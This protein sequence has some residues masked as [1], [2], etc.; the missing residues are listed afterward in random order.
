MKFAIVVGF[1]QEA[2]IVGSPDNAVVIIGG[3]NA[4]KLAS[5]LNAAIDGGCD[6]VLSFGTW[7]ALDPA[8]KAGEIGVG[9]SL[10][11][12]GLTTSCDRAWALSLIAATGARAV[13]VTI[14]AETVATAASK[15]ALRLR[16]RADVV[17]FE[18]LVAA[19]VA[20]NRG[21]K[22]AALRSASDTADQDIPPAALAA[23]RAGGGLD[24]GAVIGSLAGDVSQLP[25]LVA[26]DASSRAAFD[27]LPL[28]LA[29]IG[30]NFGAP[31]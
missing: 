24:I 21:V 7:G 29:D 30:I 27:A 4:A 12:A 13:V 1:A 26:L 28:A 17:D 20:W 22:F 15:A 23:L 16:T 5:E 25:A 8:I 11:G 18:T 14:S 31:A 19:R 9:W 6:H 3:G 2:A 10:V